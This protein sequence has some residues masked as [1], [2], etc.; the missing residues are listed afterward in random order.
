MAEPKVGMKF[1]NETTAMQRLKQLADKN[2]YH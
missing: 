1:G 2:M